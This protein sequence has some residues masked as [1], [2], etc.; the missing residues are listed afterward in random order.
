MCPLLSIHLHQGVTS[1]LDEARSEENENEDSEDDKNAAPSKKS[2]GVNDKDKND[3][4]F[5]TRRANTFVKSQT[6][7]LQQ[8]LNKFIHTII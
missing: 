8:Y 7:L 6:K 2:P 1:F 5:Y 4:N 3:P